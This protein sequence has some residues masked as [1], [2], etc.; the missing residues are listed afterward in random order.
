MANLVWNEKDS[1]VL[2]AGG[3]KGLRARG[4]EA[5]SPPGQWSRRPGDSAGTAGALPAAQEAL[6]PLQR[7]KFWIF[8]YSGIFAYTKYYI[9]GMRPKSNLKF[10]FHLHLI[11]NSLKGI[12]YNIFSALEFWLQTISCVSC[13]I[14]HSCY[15][16]NI[17]QVSD[18]EAF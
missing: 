13:G 5:G 2:R 16:I 10:M 15:P 4:G 6:R 7:F 11:H 9:L 14:F 18:F 1:P 3:W 8:F 12:L 17:K